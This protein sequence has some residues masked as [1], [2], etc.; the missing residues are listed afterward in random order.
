MKYASP[1]ENPLKWKLWR[2]DHGPGKPRRPLPNDI[3]DCTSLEE[4]IEFLCNPSYNTSTFPVP[5]LRK[6]LT[7][8]LADVS[9]IIFSYLIVT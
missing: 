5:E 8:M 9:F 4:F 1:N 7:S 6:K 2:E 3:S